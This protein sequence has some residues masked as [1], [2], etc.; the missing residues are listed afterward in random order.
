MT[1]TLIVASALVSGP[2]AWAHDSGFGLARYTADGALDQSFGTAGVVVTR[3]TQ[4]SFVAN[5]LALQ[6][7]GR[8]LIAG[9]ASDLPTASLQLA[10]ARY[11]PDGSP[12]GA[13]GTH[14]L[15]TTSAGPTGAQATAL[16]LQPDGKIL[17]AGTV[18]AHGAEADEFAL[19][20]FL[21]DGK[22]DSSFGSGGIVST[23]VGA[24]ASAGQ[25]LALQPDGRIVVVG[26]AYSN[27]PTDDDFAVVR[28]TP[29]GRLDPEFGTRG[30][31]TTDF[32]SGDAGA[33]ASL[34]RA[35]GVAIGADARIVVAGSTRGDHQTFAVARY[36]P[37]GSLD[38]SFG[39][40]GKAQVAATDPQVYALVIQPE[41]SV[42]LAGTAGA[43]GPRPTS[44]ATAPFALIR[45]LAD[46]WADQSFGSAGL[47][48]TS[49]EGSRSGARTA[50]AQTDGKLLIG[51]AKFGA[52][53]A[54][55]DA[56]P[57]SG[58]A[59]ARYNPDGSIDSGFGVGGRVLTSMGDAGATPL[60]LAVQP[61]G[62]IVAA[63]LVFF[64]VPT[65]AGPFDGALQLIAPAAA[66]AMLATGL[67]LAWRLRRRR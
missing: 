15:A 27:G 44:G 32:G 51:G 23:H 5:A 17:A 65:P 30:M 18:F 48:T 13:F 55:G 7:D 14:G 45:F 62:K 26:T 63:G 46:G 12:D 53:S 49:F 20:R 57:E 43:P 28:Y 21:A 66:L 47:V 4:R 33:R 36:N 38:S 42:I 25:S 67:A 8:I 10:V 40:G 52:P 19:A 11:N 29:D 22:L 24:G 60:S 41:G 16:A 31:V 34:D 6:S 37:D 3:S 35:G 39:A 64:R 1:L 58:F 2:V 61:D 54:Q 9:M 59:L 50:I 56:L